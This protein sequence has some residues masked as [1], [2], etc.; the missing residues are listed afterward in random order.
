MNTARTIYEKIEQGVLDVSNEVS[1]PGRSAAAAAPPADARDAEACSAQTY[2]I[3][4]GYGVGGAAGSNTV[5]LDGAQSA[6][7]SGCC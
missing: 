4:V 6:P 3:R 1:P 2:G 7:K 5:K